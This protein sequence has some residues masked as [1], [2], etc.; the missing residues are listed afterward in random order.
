V[1]SLPKSSAITPV[2]VVPVVYLLYDNLSLQFDSTTIETRD[3]FT[4]DSPVVL[5]ILVAV[6]PKTKDPYTK[7]A[8]KALES[9]KMRIFLKSFILSSYHISKKKAKNYFIQP[10]F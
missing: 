10:S 9:I 8:A 7:N 2:E 5:T 3:F 1:E 4:S 6:I